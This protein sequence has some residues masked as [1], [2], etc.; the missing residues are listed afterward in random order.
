MGYYIRVLTPSEG[1]VAADRLR[2]TL[3]DRDPEIVI[4]AEGEG[5]WESLRISH[6]DREGI[7]DIERNRVGPG[8]LGREELDEMLDELAGSKPESAAR[9][10]AGYLPT[11]KTIYAFPVLSG[12]K[13]DSRWEVA[14]AAQEAIWS[15]TGG[16][17]QADSEGFSN[18]DGHHILWQF[19]DDVTG[20]WKM[21]VLESGRW[22][23]FEMDLGNPEHRSAFLAGRVPDG[24]KL[25]GAGQGDE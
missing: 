14:H 5:D 11:V 19:S 7:V 2:D 9:W 15:Q 17:L 13:R 12:D 22:V 16:V 21:A 1:C 8:T 23:R 4:E 20:P 25:V 18:E 3:R 6:P 24:A 10:L